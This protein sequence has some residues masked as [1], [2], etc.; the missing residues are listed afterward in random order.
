MKIPNADRAV[1]AEDKLRNYLLN[2]AHRR[3][4]PKA[5][6]LLSMGYR[7]DDWQSLE[8]DIRAQHLTAE[9]DCEGDTEYGRRYE[10]VA[11]LHGPAGKAVVFRSIWQVDVE[12]DYPR[13]IT[14]YP[15]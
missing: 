9:V 7:P 2:L 13:L 15:E 4:G 1:I 11:P 8:G 12:T 5:K 3:G 10:I 6:M 14:M